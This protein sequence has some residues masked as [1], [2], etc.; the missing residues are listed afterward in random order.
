MVP[1][2]FTPRADRMHSL[3]ILSD[4]QFRSNGHRNHSL[5]IVNRLGVDLLRKEDPVVIHEIRPYRLK[6]PGGP[7]PIYR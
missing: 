6:D 4:I 5:R 3:F 1:I 7:H 2:Y